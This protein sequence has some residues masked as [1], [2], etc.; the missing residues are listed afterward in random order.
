MERAWRRTGV[1][2]LVGVV[3]G[4]A[5]Q[6]TGWAAEDAATTNVS[7]PELAAQSEQEMRGD[8]AKIDAAKAAYRQQM[9]TLEAKR[10]AAVEAG[11]KEQAA[12]LTKQIHAARAQSRTALGHTQQGRRHQQAPPGH[13]REYHAAGSDAAP[14]RRHVPP[15]AHVAA[16]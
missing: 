6:V 1:I 4:W 7:A 12:A 5:G 15:M 14:R 2:V 8:T 11:D 13:R 3:V 10:K 9:K 16:Q